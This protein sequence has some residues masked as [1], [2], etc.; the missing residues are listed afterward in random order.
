L[1]CSACLSTLIVSS[2]IGGRANAINDAS[3]IAGTPGIADNSRH[4][5]AW[6]RSSGIVDIN[7]LNSQDALT[8]AFSAKV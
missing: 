8:V 5:F 7:T 4:A 1:L 6:T 2:Q 3:L